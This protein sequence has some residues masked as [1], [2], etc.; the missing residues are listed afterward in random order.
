MKRSPRAFTLVELLAV[1]GIV[2]L[3]I[4]MIM[5]ALSKAREAARLTQCMSGARQVFFAVEMYCNDSHDFYPTIAPISF[6][7]K[8]NPVPYWHQILIDRNYLKAALQTNRGG[9]PDGPSPRVATPAIPYECWP[10]DTPGGDY[11]ART[12]DPSSVCY[13]LNGILQSGFC[14]KNPQPD[15]VN[16]WAY[17]SVWKRTSGAVRRH[18][19]TVGVIFCSHVPW[20]WNTEHLYP[21]LYYCSGLD[22][23]YGPPRHKG[24]AVPVA[25]ADGHV[26][27]I[28]HK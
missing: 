28:T 6:G 13:G 22:H 5:P 11:Y 4:A 24:R 10:Y 26:E 2:A 15:G 18:A 19:T 12:D 7:L 16:W 3:L 27:T 20:I 14:Y 1:I 21:A 25:C 9:C 23:T 17:W 8:N